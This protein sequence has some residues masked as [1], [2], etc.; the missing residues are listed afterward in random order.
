MWK[1]GHTI[2]MSNC[3][4]DHLQNEK[5]LTIAVNGVIHTQET[6]KNL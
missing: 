5:R 6:L 1:E 3:V 4:I 2:C